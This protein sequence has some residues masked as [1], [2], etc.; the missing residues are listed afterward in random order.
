V[1]PRTAS[2]VTT[3]GTLEV[4]PGVVEQRLVALQLAFELGQLRLERARVDIGQQVSAPDDLPS[5][6]PIKSPSTRLFTVTYERSADRA[7]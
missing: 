1:L 5:G 7:R 3:P 2:V 4:E 6:R